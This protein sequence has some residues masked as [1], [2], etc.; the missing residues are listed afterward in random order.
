MRTPCIHDTILNCH[1]NW[2]IANECCI[3]TLLKIRHHVRA[4]SVRYCAVVVLAHF[5]CKSNFLLA[6][7]AMLDQIYSHFARRIAFS[8]GCLFCSKFC[9][10]ILSGPSP[11]YIWDYLATLAEHAISYQWWSSG[12]T[13]YVSN[14]N[15]NYILSIWGS[16]VSLPKGFTTVPTLIVRLHPCRD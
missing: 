11:C 2:V 16:G 7:F 6:Y 14:D 1:M 4:C 8:F 9:K 13:C 15:N 10:Q 12:L 5:K 3:V